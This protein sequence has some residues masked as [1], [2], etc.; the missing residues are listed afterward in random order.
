VIC[1]DQ[2]VNEVT[3]NIARIKPF[4]EDSNILTAKMGN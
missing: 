2:P 1:C 4:M 3:K